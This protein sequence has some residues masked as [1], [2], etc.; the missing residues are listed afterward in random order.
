M[1]VNCSICGRSFNRLTWKHLKTHNMTVEEYKK[2]FGT[3]SMEG[4]SADIS[5]V[6]SDLQK[7]MS[8]GTEMSPESAKMVE[9]VL[10]DPKSRFHV[11][12]AVLAVNQI[13]RMSKLLD[14]VDRAE[15]KLF[16]QETLDKVNPS[17][18][19]MIAEYSSMERDKIIE[20]IKTLI[21]EEKPA[22]IRDNNLI[23]NVLPGGISIP[24]DANKRRELVDFLD[25][26][27]RSLSEETVVEADIVVRGGEGGNGHS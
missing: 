13:S 3:I 27:V 17:Q 7:L 26:L 15:N 8:S 25:I 14:V 9:N 23:V 22:E 2:K 5:P 18:L 6:L 16:A 21:V 10:K 4:H 24:K 12:L 20:V 1:A 19:R 11:V